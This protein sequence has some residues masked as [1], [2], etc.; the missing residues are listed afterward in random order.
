MP[1]RRKKIR[2][3]R[4]VAAAAAAAASIRSFPHSTTTFNSTATERL[5]EP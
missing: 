4:A 5:D 3:E 2:K 1:G